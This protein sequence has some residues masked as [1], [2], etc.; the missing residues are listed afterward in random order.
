MRNARTMKI[1]SDTLEQIKKM[2]RELS[3]IEEKDLAMSE[4]VK[5]MIS[6]EEIRQRLR[7]GS[8]ERKRGK[9]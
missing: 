3:I 1:D 6:V 8:E 5:R 9:K 7:L 2:K 4:I